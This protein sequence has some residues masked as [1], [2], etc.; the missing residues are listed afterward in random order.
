[1]KNHDKFIREIYDIQRWFH[2]T[3]YSYKVAVTDLTAKM[4]R[5][6]LMM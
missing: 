6:H 1:M 5:W 2:T 4:L 3:I